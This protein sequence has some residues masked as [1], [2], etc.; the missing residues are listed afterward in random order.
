M[1]ISAFLVKYETEW[2]KR[3]HKIC[4]SWIVIIRN[5]STYA[6]AHVHAHVHIHA[7]ARGHVHANTYYANTQL[8]L[9]ERVGHAIDDE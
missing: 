3:D 7:D 2:L 4:L 6:H 8:I 9:C 1:S 5:I